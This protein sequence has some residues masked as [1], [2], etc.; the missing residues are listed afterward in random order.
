[1]REN[2]RKFEGLA[3]PYD[4]YRPGYPN[5]IFAILADNVP[6]DL[7][8][9]IDVGAGTGISTAALRRALP[10]N[11]LIIA[12]EPGTD[13]RRVLTRRFRGVPQVQAL[14]AAAEA[15]SVPDSSVSLIVA[16]T[17]FHWFDRRAFFSEAARLLVPGG[18]LAIIRNR[19]VPDPVVQ[20]FDAFLGTHLVDVSDMEKRER[21]K[22]PSVR[23]LAALPDFKAAK[24][25]TA[26]WQC[27][28]QRRAFID[29]YLTRSTTAEVVRSLGLRAVIDAFEDIWEAAG[30]GTE[31]DVQWETT[32]KWAKRA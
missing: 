1:M 32:L 24:S 21:A 22:E 7:P 11:W 18:L 14:D 12:V 31:H 15:I 17:A 30:G 16:C 25:A 27:S 20:G 29:L 10:P 6:R 26:R 19:R 13:M 28:M 8:C 4:A 9:A 5:E 23:D 3:E 2:A